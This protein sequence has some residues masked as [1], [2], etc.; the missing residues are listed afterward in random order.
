[1]RSPQSERGVIHVSM[2]LDGKV[3]SFEVDGMKSRGDAKD[4]S[5]LTSLLN[6]DQMNDVFVQIQPV[7]AGRIMK[8]G[9]TGFLPRQRRFKLRSIIEDAGGARLHYVRERGSKAH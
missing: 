5:T 3:L 1:M 7:I 4:L 6:D 9:N 8:N 2:T